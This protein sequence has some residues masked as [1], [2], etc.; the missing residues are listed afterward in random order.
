[1][2]LFSTLA[3]NIRSMCE[4]ASKQTP[5]LKF[6]RAGTAPSRFEIPGSA[7]GIYMYM[8]QTDIVNG[9]KISFEPYKTF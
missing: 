4:G 1:M 3:I 6:Y 9:G 5:Y 8:L 7:T 2:Y